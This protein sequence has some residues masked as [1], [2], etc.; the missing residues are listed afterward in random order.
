MTV[1]P[2]W[3]SRWGIYL[4]TPLAWVCAFVLLAVAYHRV[5]RSR[6]KAIT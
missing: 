3:I 5:C 2:I 4:A 1:L 6:E